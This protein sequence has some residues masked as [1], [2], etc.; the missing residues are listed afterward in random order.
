MVIKETGIMER[1]NVGIL[2][3]PQRKTFSNP[4]FH[5]SII[6]PGSPRPYGE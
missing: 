5:Y 2:G 1:W 4:S 6:P 3:E